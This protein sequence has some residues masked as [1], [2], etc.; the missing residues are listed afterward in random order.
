[1]ITINPVK[2]NNPIHFGDTNPILA[3][4]NPNAKQNFEQNYHEAIKA[5]AVQTLPPKAILEKL[6]KT[7]KL[8][9]PEKPETKPVENFN[10]M[11]YQF[12]TWA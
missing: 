8:I 4:Q 9:F 2:L 6:H 1:M 10:L 12:R 5:D 3:L 11:D 7:Y